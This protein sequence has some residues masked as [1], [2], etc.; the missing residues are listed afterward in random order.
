[1]TYRIREVDT[2][3][4]DVTETLADL[5]R[6]TFFD[7]API[8]AFD[9]GHW[10]I[11]YRGE[12]PVSFAA[13]VPSDRYPC[14]GYFNRVGVTDGHRG[15]GLQLRHMRALEARAKRNGWTQVVSDTTDNV[16]SANNFI[17]AG[18]WMLTPESPWALPNSI[19]W[20]KDL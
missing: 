9:Q 3:D 5:H 12:E 20:I 14:A 8:P 17:A 6:M 19:Y 1:M 15:H 16:P 11:G 18:Y 13:L 2:S 10:W 7:A 4:E